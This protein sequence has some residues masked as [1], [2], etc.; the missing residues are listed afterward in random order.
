MIAVPRGPRAYLLTLAGGVVRTFERDDGKVEG[1]DFVAAIV[2]PSNRWLYL[3]TEDGLCCCF[4]VSTGKIEK[5]IRGFAEESTG[6]TGGG[7]TAEVAALAHHPQSSL[8]AA[9]SSEKGQK[10][11]LLTLWK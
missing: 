1:G 8:L 2:S 10:R 11:G 9:Y 3:A 6:S 7:R 5:T 4:D